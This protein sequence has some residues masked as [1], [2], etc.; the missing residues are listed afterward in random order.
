MTDRRLF[1]R[2]AAPA[3]VSPFAR[4]FVSYGS[5]RRA[6]EEFLRSCRR[7]GLTCEAI[8]A[9][10]HVARKRALKR[11]NRPVALF[12]D[13]PPD[14]P[15]L[16]PLVHQVIFPAWFH[17]IPLCFFSPAGQD[18]YTAGNPRSSSLHTAMD[19]IEGF[20]VR[21]QMV[22]ILETGAVLRSPATGPAS[23]LL[24]ES[25]PIPLDLNLD[26][27]QSAAARHVRGPL[28]VLAPAGS[29]KTKTLVNRICNLVNA[30]VEPECILPLAFNRK[31]AAEMNE[32]LVAKNLA[33]VRGR[34]FHSLGYEIV[35]SA[36]RLIFDEECEEAMMRELLKESLF[37]LHPTQ[38]P[39]EGEPLECLVRLVSEVKR[40]L[41]PVEGIQFHLDGGSFPFGPLFL[42]HIAL[43]EER[44]FM[45]YEDMIY[46]ALRMLLDDDLLRKHYQQ[47]FRYILVDEFQDLNRAQLLFLR[48]LSFP[49]NNLFVVGD[50]DQLIYGWR[51]ANLRSIIDFPR[52]HPCA[53][54]IR[55]STNYRSASSIVCHAGWLI[56]RNSDRVPKSVMPR[57]GAPCGEFQIA[58]G[59]G[60]WEQA[61][62]AADWIAKKPPAARWRDTAVLYRYNALRYVVALALDE[63]DIPHTPVDPVWL[64]DS[65]AGK[66]IT[67]WLS[68]ALA[69]A[70]AGHDVLER[71]LRR[72]ERLVRRSIVDHLERW[73]DIEK[74]SGSGVLT[75]EEERA[76]GRF[77]PRV[78]ELES[79]VPLLAPG[80]FIEM[81]DGMI[82]L[83]EWYA[84]RRIHSAD[85]EEADERTCLDVLDALSRRFPSAAGFLDHIMAAHL[86][87]TGER[88]AP[89]T[90]AGTD[91]VVLS[92]VHRAKG[93]E[94]GRVVFFDLTRRHRPPP[95]QVEEERR[96]AYVAL[97]RA[98][99]ALLVTANGRR[100]S[101]F[102]RE[103]ALDPQ[104][105]GRMRED[106]ESE[107][108]W[109]RKRTGNSPVIREIEEELRCRSML[110]R[111]PSS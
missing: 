49:E 63:R 75:S 108:A 76:L 32:R 80:G 17:G 100:Q 94:F 84:R 86:Q 70:S 68:V 4:G 38:A 77:F 13:I 31:A 91:E 5:T 85:P 59:A 42:R 46:R 52:L 81:L 47:E 40:D 20:L 83:R 107:L 36:S 6:Y 66:D 34:T 50:D 2:R 102:L 45:T 89:E 21:E 25:A 95:D 105:A 16:T 69:P 93:N 33:R 35:R 9:S 27:G 111:D 37:S 62:S 110:S 109:L 39:A 14:S 43:Q 103:A 11:L 41:L 24:R 29:G 23:R 101:P 12:Q 8:T 54:E 82:H 90:P 60:L 15:L 30:G 19:K 1:R 55:L 53:C 51:G 7:I 22:R 64:F 44:G 72:P 74:L 99:D 3:P 87:P 18:E 97:T 96:V 61:R 106:L 88:S 65:P 28:R 79:R 57:A 10:A 78:R 48:I 98:R 58:L 92:T 56:G 26:V 67:A 71:V 104:F 73:D